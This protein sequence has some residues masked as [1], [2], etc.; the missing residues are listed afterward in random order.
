M[1][2]KAAAV[3]SVDVEDWF[4]IL[5]VPGTPP[6][7]QWG[8]LPARV[9]K[10]FRTMLEVFAEKNVHTTLFFLAWV[11]ERYPHLV[12]EAQAGGHEI[13]SHGYAHELVYRQDAATFSA[14]IR[15]AKD[16]LEQVA[17]V[18]V[19]GYRAP[20]FSVTERTPWF[21][22]AVL[23]AGYT[24]DSSLFP[25]ARGHGGLPGAPDVPHVI[26][27][28]SGDLIEFPISL[29]S[30]LGRRLYFFGGGYLRFFPYPL[31]RRKAKEVLAEGRP[32]VIY[33]HPRE[34]D[35]AHPRL[36]MG[37]KRRFMTYY[38]LRSTLPKMRRLCDDLPLRTFAAL[39][40]SGRDTFPLLHR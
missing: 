13:A 32:V 17:G 25:A 39:A 10:G 8:A 1:G 37:L 6:F 3:L 22:D 31:V 14:D 23:Q 36:P 7:A 19:H 16:I 33:L 38:N 30:F 20:G 18:A 29:A 12:R 24:Y 21:F 9:E 15:R 27:C 2:T 40:A 35:P 11:A 4:H 28:A 26:R 34:V 5:D